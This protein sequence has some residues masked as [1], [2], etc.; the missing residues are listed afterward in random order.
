M[1]KKTLYIACIVVVIAAAVIWRQDLSDGAKRFSAWF[2]DTDDPSIAMIRQDLAQIS[3]PPPLRSSGDHPDANLTV[4]GVISETNR[5]RS[6]EGLMSLAE[7][8]GLRRAAELKLADMFK[9]QYFA[10][11]SPD[12]KGP[13]D[14]AQAAGYQYV[15]IGENLALGNFKNDIELVQGWM[16]SP[17]H[18]ANIMNGQYREIGVAVGQGMFEGKLTWLAVQEFGTPASACP[19]PDSDLEATITSKKSRIN[20]LDGEISEKKRQVDAYEPKR[21]EEYESLVREYNNLVQQYNT[22]VN[23]TK[24]LVATYNAS[25]QSYNECLKRY[26]HD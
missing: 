1:T 11:E 15:V 20:V 7:S 10:H 16:D 2:S 14:V 21:G 4:A 8:A 13:A 24:A 18:R 25:V 23:E 22:L 9:K 17:G 3:T 19:E 5:H 12:G 6:G 26:S